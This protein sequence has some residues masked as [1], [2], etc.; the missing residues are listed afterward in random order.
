MMSSEVSVQDPQSVTV[1][2]FCA[3]SALFSV[4][5]RLG[6]RQ[7]IDGIAEKRKQGLPVSSS[8]LLAAINRAIAP[9]SKRSFYEWFDRTVLY[10]IFPGAN[11]K[12]LSS[13]G[14]WN[15]MSVLDE[16]KIRKIEDEITKRVVEQYSIE[17]ECLLYDNT[18]FFTYIDTDNASALAK[19][20]HSKEK[21]SDLKIVGLSLMVSPDHNIPLFH[22]AYPGNRNDAL[23]FS[24]VVDKIKCRYEKLGRGACEMT[25]VFDKG[26]NNGDNIYNMIETG[27]CKSHFVG[28]LRL[29][30]CLELLEIS[31]KA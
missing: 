17:T 6:V 19:R 30:Q 29:N 28:G 15:N 27:L 10:K 2:E 23:Q 9:T 3:V 21:R 5:E 22:E 7:I 11:A 25:L 20:G 12:S 18:N 31:K 24:E 1:Y 8:I 14:F 13:Q 26:N 4:A 16:D